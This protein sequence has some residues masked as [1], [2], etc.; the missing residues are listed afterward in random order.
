MPRGV[1][2]IFLVRRQLE[3]EKPGP[4][5]LVYFLVRIHIQDGRRLFVF[6]ALPG[7]VDQPLAVFGNIQDV[8][9]RGLIAAGLVGIDQH[10]IYSVEPVTHTDGVL[11][12]VRQPPG[13]EVAAIANHGRVE[14]FGFQQLFEALGDGSAARQ[15][16]E[17][18]TRI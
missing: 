5:Q 9:R 11:V 14:A 1:V 3:A 17:H 2:D 10:F 12:L 15:R 7:P 8:D 18:G 6:P 13:E 16:V 4:W